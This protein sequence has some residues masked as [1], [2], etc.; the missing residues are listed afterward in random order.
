MADVATTA[1][2]GTLKQLADAVAQTTIRTWAMDAEILAAVQLDCHERGVRYQRNLGEHVQA[3]YHALRK[4][5]AMGGDGTVSKRQL[6]RDLYP[7]VGEDFDVAR[8]KNES[9]RRWLGILERQG[10]ISKRELRSTKGAG[11]ALGLRV[12]LLPV[13]ERVAR[14]AASRGCSSVG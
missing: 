14:L 11:K 3:I 1:V 6:A 9:I 13:P 4:R 8:K 12:G 2:A 10:L 7:E 5:Q